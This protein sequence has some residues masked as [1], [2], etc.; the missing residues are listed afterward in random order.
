[1]DIRLCA[2]RSRC[3]ACSCSSSV[4]A[5]CSFVDAFSSRFTSKLMAKRVGSTAAGALVS[6]DLVWV[7]R[8]LSCWGEP[9]SSSSSRLGISV[10]STSAITPAR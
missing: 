8:D 1:M 2:V 10:F 6:R 9:F 5:G 3:V 4:V 7:S